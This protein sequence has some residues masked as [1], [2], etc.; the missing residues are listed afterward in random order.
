MSIA[1]RSL[2]S[3]NDFALHSANSTKGQN[4]WILDSLTVSDA[5]LFVLFC[6]TICLIEKLILR[7]AEFYDEQQ[8]VTV[9]LFLKILNVFLRHYLLKYLDK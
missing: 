5:V 8:G 7:I 6:Y 9:I 1:G 4:S 3:Q 2:K